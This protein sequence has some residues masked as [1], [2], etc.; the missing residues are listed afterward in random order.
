M[1]PTL[2]YGALLAIA[3]SHVAMLGRAAQL[4]TFDGASTVAVTVLMSNYGVRERDGTLI[5]RDDRRAIVAAETGVMPDP[6][7][8]RLVL[9]GT[10]FRIVSVRP[11]SPAGTVLYFDCQVRGK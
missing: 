5:G 7:L 6:E 2:D 3:T 8:H 4:V 9:D 1:F 11:L 10:S